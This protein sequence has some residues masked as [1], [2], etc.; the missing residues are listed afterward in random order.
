MPP[1]DEMDAENAL[2]PAPPPPPIPRS[3]T[4]EVKSPDPE[5]RKEGKSRLERYIEHTSHATKEAAKREARKVTL[6]IIDEGAKAASRLLA[7][8]RARVAGEKRP[9]GWK[10]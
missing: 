7:D 1:E 4:A 8:F 6:V 5:V 2:M 10:E 3:I 9:P